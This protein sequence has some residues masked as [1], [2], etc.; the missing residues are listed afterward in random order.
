[1]KIFLLA[2]FINNIFFGMECLTNKNVTTKLHSDL[3]EQYRG[4]IEKL[5]AQMVTFCQK[6]NY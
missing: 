2:I 1:M 4:T 6:K 5:F 3:A